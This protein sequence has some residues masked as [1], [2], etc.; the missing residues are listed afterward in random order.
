MLQI[1]TYWARRVPSDASYWYP[2]VE[3]VDR[4]RQKRSRRMTSHAFACFS[5]CLEWTLPTYL[6]RPT[7]PGDIRSSCYHSP[8]Y[9][10]T[11]SPPVRRLHCIQQEGSGVNMRECVSLHIGQA[12]IQVGNACWELYCLEHGIQVN[13]S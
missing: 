3:L 11:P 13:T 8:R 7:W 5:S 10:S 2:N 9:P 12:G 6:S 1:I 4:K